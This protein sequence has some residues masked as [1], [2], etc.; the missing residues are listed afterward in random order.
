MTTKIIVYGKIR[1][2]THL[3]FSCFVALT[4]FFTF[5]TICLAVD[6]EEPVV[7]DYMVLYSPEAEELIG[8]EE[9]I[10]AQIS[11]S[12]LYVN[13]TLVRSG[14]GNISFNLVHVQKWVDEG[15]YADLPG[16]NLI[17]F[18]ELRDKYRADSYSK[19]T[20]THSSGA[21]GDI[22]YKASDVRTISTSFSVRNYKGRTVAHELGHNMGGYH[23][24]PATGSSMSSYG[25]N[26]VGDDGEHYKTIMSYG[27]KSELDLP[28]P[29][30]IDNY[31][32]PEIKYEGQPTGEE[33]EADMATSI[34]LWAPRIAGVYS[35]TQ[36]PESPSPPPET[37]GNQL[38][39]PLFLLLDK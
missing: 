38:G 7:I 8:G 22:P 12:V 32:N 25:Y 31:S 19:I 11:E 15:S 14:L 39:V 24:K 10:L 4:L 20:D 29:T 28:R 21:Y 23:N 34:R 18:Q 27:Y 5:S 6:E 2:L 17:S 9:I 1:F 3:S 30:T 35:G 26:F 37:G 33:G 16:D 13:E 36:I